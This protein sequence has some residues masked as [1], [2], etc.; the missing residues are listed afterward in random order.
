MAPII[1]V[2]HISKKFERRVPGQAQYQ[3]LRELLSQ[4]TKNLFKK[5]VPR[6]KTSDFWS[7]TDVSFTVEQG[8]VVGLI[9]RNGAGKSTLLKVL[10]RIIAPTTG[11]IVLRGRVSSLLEV[12]TG[13][14]PELTGRENIFMNGAILGM[15][16]EEIRKKF[17]EIVEFAGVGEFI[18]TPVKRYSSGM[19]MRLA[20]SV[21]AH[22][23]PE[24]LIVDEV[25]AVGDA[26]FQKKCLGKMKDVSNSGRT[27]IFVSH[28]I[29]AIQDLCNK[30]IW[31]D[32]GQIVEMGDDVRKITSHYI[33]GHNTFET[34]WENTDEGRMYKHPNFTP[35]SMYIA[36]SDNNL[37]TSSIKG[38]DDV[39]LY[40]EAQIDK[41]DP[42]L[43]MGYE[44]Y[45][46]DN[47]LLYWSYFIDQEESKWPE[48]KLGKNIF[49][50]KL[51]K[52]LFN[53][54]KYTVNLIAS[55][56]FR[57][58]II[59]SGESSAKISFVLQGGLSDSPM[60]RNKRYGLLAPVIPWETLEAKE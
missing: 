26:E 14:H 5:R 38:D 45:N 46:E 27:V 56:H 37:I 22:I 51:P 55:L 28:N 29:N 15:S 34:K 49:R 57:E 47:T 52:R 4:G 43:S 33:H 2:K 18:D 12:G 54:G 6:I 31:L 59:E 40:I 21:A 39:Y 30:I 20:F 58:W 9:G 44:I 35:I 25:L 13:F 32:K 48:V 60:W 7:L 23:D 1:D 24:I 10:S 42:A 50:T 36:D 8:D 3:T 53:E 17:D 16:Q 19:Y 11:E 41:L